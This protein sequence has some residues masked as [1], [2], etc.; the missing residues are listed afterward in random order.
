MI[1]CF[2]SSNAACALHWACEGC[3]GNTTICTLEL[4]SY[5]SFSDDLA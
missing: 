5:A 3:Y 2:A 1:D 4:L